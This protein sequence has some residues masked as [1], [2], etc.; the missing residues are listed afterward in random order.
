MTIYLSSLV[1]L[2]I[3]DLYLDGFNQVSTAH[4]LINLVFI[5]LSF[6][7]A[8]YG[9]KKLKVAETTLDE[10]SDLLHNHL[11]R[12]GSNFVLKFDEW[13]LT[14]TERRVAVLLVKG[15][16]LKEIA[17]YCHRGEGTIR[18]HAV[19]VY[20]KSGLAG[21]AE[22]A[23]HFLEMAVNI[24]TE[25]ELLNV[26]PVVKEVLDEP[27]VWCVFLKRITQ[28]GVDRKILL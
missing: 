17:E 10:A 24:P 13:Q 21:R 27:K 4:V 11:N 28:E 3:L 26:A 23:G 20:N 7:A 22:L 6:I 9:F 2:G 8:G 1:A 19:A 25:K 18:Q 14:E 16:S 15:R 12:L 5:V